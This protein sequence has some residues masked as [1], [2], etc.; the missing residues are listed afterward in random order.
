[1]KQAL[2]FTILILFLTSNILAL[3]VTPARN[4]IDFVPD[5]SGGG[6]FK[7]LNTENI[8][9][10]LVIKTRGE[11]GSNIDLDKR[12]VNFAAGEKESVVN[13]GLTLPSTLSPGLHI[14]EIVISEPEEEI[15]GGDTIVGAKL[16]VVTQIYVYVP[17][18]S[19]SLS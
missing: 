16:S 19:A 2:C 1:M 3:G 11:L 6:S 10:E 18:P 7:I 14:G 4:T 15:L 17:V 5:Y 8:E 13:Y 12:R 9:R